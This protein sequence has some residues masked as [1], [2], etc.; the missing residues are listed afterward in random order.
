MASNKGKKNWVQI[1]GL[2][3]M[4]VVF[5]LVSWYYLQTGL[6]YRLE[7]RAEQQ[8][9]ANVPNQNFSNYNGEEVALDRFKDYLLIG[10]FY[11]ESHK[12]KYLPLL[13]KLYH[14]FDERKDVYFVTFSAD[15][16]MSAVVNAKQMLSDS[17][18]IDEEQVFFLNSTE[19]K[20]LS[21]ALKLPFEER[22]MSLVDNSLLFFADSA[23]VKGFYDIKQE[24]DVKRLVKHITLN[25]HPLEEKDI[26]FERE[27]EK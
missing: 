25:L 7:A 23:V 9:I 2:L 17:M 6:N 4:L 21:S 13:T 1:G 20:A 26:I 15:T 14:Q 12:D 19:V 16:S 22:N 8:A 5:P 11:S 27:T 18:L 3:L 10:H 24:E